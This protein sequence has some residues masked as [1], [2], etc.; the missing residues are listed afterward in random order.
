MQHLGFLFRQATS[1]IL[2]IRVQSYLITKLPFSH[3]LP[4]LCLHLQRIIRL[5]M[6][7]SHQDR[8]LRR[9]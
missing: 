5:T 3:L 9:Y 6:A 1:L 2:H 7:I 8:R 4:R